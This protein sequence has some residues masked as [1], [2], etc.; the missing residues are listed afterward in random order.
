[1]T[2]IVAVKIQN[3]D[4]VPVARLEGEIDI[5]NASEIGI[6][7][8]GAAPNTAPGLVVDLSRTTYLDSRGVQMLVEL[9]ERMR[10]RQQ[11]LRVVVP[12]RSVV[13]RVLQLSHL[14]ASVPLDHTVEE[15]VTHLRKEQ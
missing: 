7:L 3:Q 14:D 4:T 5:L 2:P 8:F 13:R 11:R 15:A 6:Q 9:A 10:R 12:E 1:M